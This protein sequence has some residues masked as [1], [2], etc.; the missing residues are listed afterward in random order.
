MKIHPYRWD[1]C[2]PFIAGGA[3]SLVGVLLLHFIQPGSGRLAIVEKLGLIMP[4]VLVYA[5]V[6]V[7]LRF[8]VEDK[9]VFD[10][11]RAKFGKQRSSKQLQ[12][13]P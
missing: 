10:A 5:L 9:M 13:L 12:V 7:V 6:M 2:K 8:S 11:V 3:A 1:V 4:F